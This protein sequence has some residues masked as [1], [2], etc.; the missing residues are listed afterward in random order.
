MNVEGICVDSLG[1]SYPDGTVALDDVSFSVQPGDVFALLGPNGSGKSTT[2]H[3]L[4]T[5]LKAK[6]GHVAVLGYDINSETEKYRNRLGVVF[7]R[8]SLD[9]ELTVYENLYFYGALKKIPKK[10][11]RKKI[12]NVLGI[13]G[14]EEKADAAA[15]TLSGGL[16]RRVDLARVFLGEPDILFLDEPTYAI[17]PAM[18]AQ[19]H[20]FLKELCSEGELTILIATHDLFEA[21]TLCNKIGF[22]NKGKLVAFAEP[23]A[24]KH[25]YS[26]TKVKISF[27]DPPRFD[28][29]IMAGDYFIESPTDWVFP[30][31]SE[32]QSLHELLNYC[33]SA[34]TVVRI[35]HLDAS[36]EDVFVQLAK[37]DIEC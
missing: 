9:A 6:K 33:M 36:L 13:F 20:Q 35:D 22:L 1:F 29:S 27:A 19:F 17:D 4:T 2:I 32:G 16:Y 34:G 25:Y 15:R 30:Y 31:N 11:L 18:K 37:G 3:I 23:E 10:E 7:Q 21:E 8:P 14:L 26:Q 5:L 28:A 12:D 24:L